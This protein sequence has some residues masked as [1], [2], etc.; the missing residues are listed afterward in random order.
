MKIIDMTG[1]TDDLEEGIAQWQKEREALSELFDEVQAY[2]IITR[3]TAICLSLADKA[4]TAVETSV[5]LFLPP[6]AISLIAKFREQ[7]AIL[8][9]SIAYLRYMNEGHHK[10]EKQKE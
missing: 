5:G 1:H 9:K 10:S 2:E 6:P 7:Y 8:A 4:L 3:R